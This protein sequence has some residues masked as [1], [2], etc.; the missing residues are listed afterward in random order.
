MSAFPAPDHDH[1]SCADAVLKR[2]DSL[3]RSRGVRLT[4][5]RAKVLD[6]LA[7]GHQPVG[8]YEIVEAMAEEGP[9]P[10][11]VTVYRALDFLV[12]QGLAHRI[13]SRNAFVACMRERK[14]PESHGATVFLIC[15]DCGNVAEVPAEE[16][17]APLAAVCARHS[18]EAEQSVI[19]IDGLCRHCAAA[20]AT[21]RP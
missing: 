4:E 14:G 3:C 15:R 5:S 18:F 9:R 8:A 19:E 21:A 6:V 7:R 2:A 20:P 12:G 13:E 10:A 16:L 17:D 11:P 1:E